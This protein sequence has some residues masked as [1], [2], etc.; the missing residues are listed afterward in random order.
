MQLS[1]SNVERRSFR[2]CG[3]SA[4]G[5]VLLGRIVLIGA[6]ASLGAALMGAATPNATPSPP[7]LGGSAVGEVTIDTVPSFSPLNTVQL[8]GTKDAGASLDILPL[9]SGAM[10]PCAPIAANSETSW[11]C[12]AA[13]PNGANIVLTAQE[14]LGGT[15]AE[16]ATDPF[17][18]LGPPT[19]SGNADFLTTG[20][21]AG[22]GFAGATVVATVSGAPDGGCTSATNS[23]GYWSCS[24]AAPSGDWSVSATQSRADLGG[25]TSS[26]VS[27]SLDVVVDK[28]APAP[29]TITFPA[30]GT[31]VTASTVTYRGTGED[32][33]LVDIYLDNTPVCSTGVS[34]SSW[35]CAIAAPARGTHTLQ[36][37][38]RDAAGNFSSPSPAIRLVFGAASATSGPPQPPPPSATPTPSPTRTTPAPSRSVP[39]QPAAPAPPTGG[40]PSGWEQPGAFGSSIPTFTAAIAD[41]NWLFAPLAALAFLVL[42]ALPLRLLARTLLNRNRRPRIRLMGR[43]GSEPEPDDARPVNPWLAGLLPLATAVAVIVLAGGVDDQLRYLRLAVTTVTGLAI[44]NLVGVVLPARL[45][46]RHRGVDGRPRLLLLLLIAAVLAAA[47]SRATGIDPPVVAG[48]LIGTGFAGGLPARN[49]GTVRLAEVGSVTILAVLAWFGHGL[50]GSTGFAAVAAGEV[51]ATIALAGFGSAVVMILPIASLPGRVILEW[52]P[53]VWIVT[54]LVVATVAAAVLL[55]VPDDF[56]MLGSLAVAASFAA[57][58]L[59]VWSWRRFVEPALR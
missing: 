30:A 10:P 51:L 6:F 50:L 35:S 11:R 27:G 5:R 41:G 2:D 9:A 54:A 48:V 49:R 55:G 7:P 8:S 43:A 44:L 22:Q 56:P 38:Q 23:D 58:S 1:L 39:E 40:P 32:G 25:G 3:A 14:T 26:S 33:G 46:S 19:V 45:I 29:P 34:G 53:P 18:V 20:L 4:V 37:I 15:T 59:A 28:D 21:I 24:L 52:S 16:A 13:V 36:A 57:L 31:R 17:D 12:T 42:V 47:L